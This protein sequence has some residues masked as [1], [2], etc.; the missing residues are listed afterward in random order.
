M[1]AC[2]Q[3]A[4]GGHGAELPWAMR[5]RDSSSRDFERRRPCRGPG[6]P[7]SACRQP[8]VT[9]TMPHALFRAGPRTQA[10]ANGSN[11]PR[12]SWSADRLRASKTKAVSQPTQ[13]RQGRKPHSWGRASL[14]GKRRTG[15]S[16]RH[17][18]ASAISFRQ[19]QIIGR[20]RPAEDA[21]VG[22]LRQ[23]ALTAA[24]RKAGPA[25][26]PAPAPWSLLRCHGRN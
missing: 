9:V 3:V 1:T 10:D 12:N 14:K 17:R 4:R 6:A 24:W 5:R 7:R 20:R 21:S 11:E 25:R 23:H 15:G 19:S 2:E 13:R 26:A 18:T 16:A 22:H 8:Q